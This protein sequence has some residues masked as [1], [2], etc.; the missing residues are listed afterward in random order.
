[1]RKPYVVTV[2]G[3]HEKQ[4]EA[5]SFSKRSKADSFVSGLPKGTDYARSKYRDK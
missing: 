1:M 3:K 5:F 2:R 4:G